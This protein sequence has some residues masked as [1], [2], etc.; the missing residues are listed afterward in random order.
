MG[1]C[2]IYDPRRADFVAQGQ[3]F[4]SLGIG[5]LGDVTKH[6]CRLLALWFQRKRFILVFPILSYIKHVNP[7]RG[8][9]DHI[10]II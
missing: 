4:N 1:L 9:F 6:I 10:V 3:D 7:G 2:E 8:H 5:Q